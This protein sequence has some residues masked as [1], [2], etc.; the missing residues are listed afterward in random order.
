MGPSLFKYDV[1]LGFRNVH[2]I[3][4]LEETLGGK[5]PV[6]QR[7]HYS[8]VHFRSGFGIVQFILGIS[9]RQSP[10]VLAEASLH[11]P[12]SDRG[13]RSLRG[14]ERVEQ[15]FQHGRKVSQLRTFPMNC[16]LCNGK[17]Q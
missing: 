11:C 4:T 9:R 17:Q 14:S 1:C 8:T 6:T 15:H 7:R 13:T 10:R 16:L 3:A 12:W 2:E 5:L